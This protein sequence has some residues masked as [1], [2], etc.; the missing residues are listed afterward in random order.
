MNLPSRTPASVL[1]IAPWFGARDIFDFAEAVRNYDKNSVLMDLPSPVSYQE[2]AK[3]SRDFHVRAG[4]LNETVS[5][6]LN[7]LDDSSPS[8][9]VGHQPN[10]LASLNVIIQPS[11]MNQLAHLLN[12][13]QH[14]FFV[15]ID[16]DV[17]SDRR[18]RHAIFPSPIS[19]KGYHS[20]QFPRPRDM[21]SLIMRSERVPTQLAVKRVYNL[22]EQIALQ[23]LAMIKSLGLSVP[24]AAFQQNL[25]TLSDF[26][27]GARDHSSTLS[28]MNGKILSKLINESFG[29]PAAFIEGSK[30]HAAMAGHFEYLWDKSTALKFSVLWRLVS[31]FR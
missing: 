25:Y 27:A 29:L 15:L 22:I 30:L 21:S 13:R 12:E 23:D 10:F 16:F 11:V 7:I 2:V 18:Y 8:L 19:G 14:Q 26:L 28:Q 9:A 24:R 6:T 20:L 5:A 17:A 4:T 1:S 31:G 3:L